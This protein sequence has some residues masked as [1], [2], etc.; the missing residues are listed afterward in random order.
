MTRKI[1]RTAIVLLPLCLGGCLWADAID[2][3]SWS[4]E[5]VAK[6]EVGKTTRAQV[7]EWLGPPRQLLRLTEGEALVY[8]CSL[9]KST[10]FSIIVAST[11]RNDKQYDAV[12]VIV[13]RDG[14]VTAV[15]SRFDRDKSA[16]GMPW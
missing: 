2:G 4:R 10:G 6:I 16:H 12:T 8:S 7:L 11:W 3:S 1:V 9:E 13:N 15:G 5:T 14:I